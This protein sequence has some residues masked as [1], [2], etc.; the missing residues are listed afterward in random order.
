[1]QSHLTVFGMLGALALAAASCSEGSA[2]DVEV[3]AESCMLCHNGSLHDD[4]SGPG[5][6]NPHPFGPGE[7]IRCTTCHGG[8]AQGEFAADSHVPPPPEIGDREQQRRDPRAW[9][10]KLTLTGIDKFPDYEVGGRTYTALDYLRFLNPADLRVTQ[11]GQGCGQCHEAH[12]DAVAGS[13][14]ATEAGVLA[15]AMF[16][17]GVDNAVPENVGLH[18]D[19]AVD[20]GFRAFLDVHHGSAPARRGQVREILEFPVYSRRG[21]EGPR[22]LFRSQLYTAA[23]LADDVGPDGRLLTDSP[24]ADL[25]HEQI[26]FTCGNC[27]LG[28]SGA[29]NRYGDFRPS[30]CAACHM[31]YSLDGR[32]RSRD[33]NV[34]KTEPL[35]P[36]DIDEPERAHVRSHRILSVARTL[37]DGEFVPGIDDHACAGCHQGSNR[38]VMQYWGIRLDQNQDLRRRV[39]YPANP[40]SFRNTAGDTRLFDPA[41]GNRTFNGRNANQYIAFEDYDGDGR[42][43]TPA[44]VHHEAG[45]GCIDC[46]GSF[47]LHGGD[48]HDP[49]GSP[50]LSRMGQAVGITCESCHGG[51]ESHAATTQGVAM[52]GSVQQVAV[53]RLG[54]PLDNVVKDA[55]GNYW[56]TSR[57]TGRRHY[58]PQTRDTIVD[59]G[60]VH[61]DTQRPIYTDAASYAMGRAGGTGTDGI[62]PIQ[63]H[64]NID[65]F[66]HLDRM[67]CASCHAAWTN[68][69]MGCHLQGE[70]DNGNNF[71]NITGERIVFRE[72][73]ADF[74]YQSPLFFQLG[75]GPKGKITQLSANTKVF[76]SYTDLNGERSRVFAFSDRRG[77]GNDRGS[78]AF[79]ALSHN[80]IMAHSIRG[81]VTERDEG[82]RAC[83]AC[84]LT[85]EGLGA[86]R[87]D[88]DAFRAAL[89]E[90][91]FGDLDFALLR[92]H[93]GQNTG[94]QLGSPFFAHMA[95]GLG[96][97]LFLFDQHGCAVNPLDQDTNRKGCDGTAPATSFDPTRVRFDLDRIV[98]PSGISNASSNHP[99]LDPAVGAALRDGA[100]D[101]TMSGPL[102][103]S[104][105][106]L[107]SDPDNGLVLDAWFDAD[108]QLRGEAANLLQN[109]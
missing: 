17:A 32:S 24:L 18:E 6:E 31:P 14:L 12:S 78:S 11:A 22:S 64:R 97:G 95:A 63:A 4:Y 72:D 73:N 42:D 100:S 58:L 16:A 48:V 86:H 7:P 3:T 28:S 108:G 68:T 39:Q 37:P 29:N 80:A 40:D 107:L 66:S 109:R 5:L 88:Y 70:Y 45:M 82:P 74:V 36:D 61:P 25:Y 93:L 54:N 94:N 102:G 101:P 34:P 43:D 2:R 20:K 50:L 91:R 59:S 51:L 75:V 27:H 89:T 47:D 90:R 53:D 35:D 52:D 41:V 65:G 55:D 104:L 87:A 15:G 8:D 96:T 106:R 81:R 30:G 33:P 60:K 105:I 56:L 38:T 69:C 9:F 84:H 98:E 26:A 77:E 71:S 67:D 57:L 46:H 1:M 83:V 62:G 79:P 76:F 13:L 103:A 23:G 85:E 44:D 10:N 99:L 21:V 92:E 19:T 49:A